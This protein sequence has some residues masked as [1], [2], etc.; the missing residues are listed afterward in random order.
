M[1]QANLGH[2]LELLLSIGAAYRV[3]GIAEDEDLGPVGDGLLEEI[4]VDGIGITCPDQRRI[5]KGPPVED[6]VFHKM[7]INRGLNQDALSGIGKGEEREIQAADQAGQEKELFVPDVPAVESLEVFPYEKAQFLGR[8]SVPEKSLIDSAPKRLEDGFR[9]NEIHVR[10]PQGKDFVTIFLPFDAVAAPSLPDLIEIVSH[11]PSG[12]LSFRFIWVFRGS[13][14]T[15]SPP[16]TAHQ[17][18]GL[19]IGKLLACLHNLRKKP[20]ISSTLP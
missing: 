2:A 11:Q 5:Y 1:A 12:S 17:R 19:V 6:R 3:V 15:A 10:H 16:L 18:E 20:L 4:E 7:V 13:P 14:A 9:R 8:A